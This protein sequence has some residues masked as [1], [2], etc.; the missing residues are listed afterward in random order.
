MF[1]VFLRI[2]A[3]VVV[4]IASFVVMT[5]LAALFFCGVLFVVVDIRESFM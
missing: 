3:S 1:W 5:I 2:L 4:I